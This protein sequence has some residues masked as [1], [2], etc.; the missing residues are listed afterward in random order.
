M[1]KGPN[2]WRTRGR[3]RYDLAIVLVRRNRPVQAEQHLLDAAAEGF[4]VKQ[5]LVDN[6]DLK[7]LAKRP[8]VAR[9]F[10][11]TKLKR[12]PLLIKSSPFPIDFAGEPRPDGDRPAP[13]TGVRF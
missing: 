4:L 9:L 6:D 10:Q 7:V 1:A 8:R 2:E 12:N 11:Q 13:I 3:A 5:A